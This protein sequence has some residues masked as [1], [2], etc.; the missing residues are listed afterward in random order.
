MKYSKIEKPKR[1]N[2]WLM[3]LCIIVCI[4]ILFITGVMLYCNTILGLYPISGQSMYPLLNSSGS[5]T[6][7]VYLE[8][9]KNHLNYG[10]VV[11]YEKKSDNINVIKRVIAKSGDNIMVDETKRVD[12][13]TGNYIYSI[14]IQYNGVGDWLEVNED[15]IENKSI[16]NYLYID[17]YNKTSVN[18]KFLTDDQGNKYLHIDDGYIFCLGDNRQNSTDCADYGEAEVENVIGK[19][20]FI[21]YPNE[22]RIWQVIKQIFGINKWK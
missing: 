4:V 10:D 1:I 20:K 17:F 9:D 11:V 16:N 19:V 3:T 12:E 22:N 18:K 6:D 14:F 15:Y 8:Y 21:I 7:F 13:N 2:I 5:D